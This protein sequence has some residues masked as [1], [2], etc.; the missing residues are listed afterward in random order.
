MTRGVYFLANDDFIE[1]AIGFLSSFR[2]HNPSIPLCFIPFAENCAG[3]AGLADRYDFTV[4]SDD[5]V[6]RTCD[7]ISR[8]FHDGV[9]MGHYRKLAMWQGD[10][11]EFL[12]VDSDT[13]VLDSVDVV[14]PYLDRYD[15]VTSHSHIPE[16]RQ[17]VWR[18]SIYDTGLLNR[19]QI[20]YAT[21]TGFVTS[22][23]GLIDP[24][25]VLRDLAAP[26]ALAPHMELLCREQ[27]LLNYLIVT[28]GQPYSSLS[29][30][31]EETNDPD[32][33][34]EQWAGLD[35]GRVEAGR[36]VPSR[37]SRVLLVHWAGEWERVR[38]QGGQLPYH[39]LWQ[40]Y[41]AM[42]DDGPPAGIGV[43]ELADA[44]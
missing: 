7:E 44:R 36:L 29:R 38:A 32:I 18:E 5:R 42:A 40:H 8:E 31:A 33:P 21:N 15:F 41:R 3:V 23:A 9:T 28:S 25:E 16:I 17:W 35:I 2:F 1:R 12:Y 19:E 37:V 22:R 27:P 20:E 43:D 24:E 13:I 11:D 39:E 30:I 34:Q 14:F 10:F 6:L 4:W 26:L